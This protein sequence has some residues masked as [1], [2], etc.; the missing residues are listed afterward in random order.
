MKWRGR[1]AR[2]FGGSLTSKTQNRRSIALFHCLVYTQRTWK[3]VC[4]RHLRAHARGGRC[5]NT[6]GGRCANVRRQV[7]ERNLRAH[8]HARLRR[9]AGPAAA[10][11]VAARMPVSRWTGKPRYVRAMQHG[12][13]ITGVRF[14]L[15]PQCGRAPR[16]V[17]EADTVGAPRVQPTRRV[18]SRACCWRGWA[19]EG[20]TWARAPWWVT[21]RSRA[22]E[23]WP[24]A[25]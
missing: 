8:T 3:Q 16:S 4:E 14:W 18:G 5:A 17:E 9:Q 23:R 24:A 19:G 2:R 20:L 10:E 15:A 25:A 7:R 21:A 13:A 22:R 6:Y 1:C 12:S 11:R